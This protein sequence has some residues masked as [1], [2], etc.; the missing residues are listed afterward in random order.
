MDLSI[1]NPLYLRSEAPQLLL[2]ALVS[3]VDM[4]DAEYLRLALGHEAA[5]DQSGARPYIGSHHG[6]PL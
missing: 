5:Y 4:I 1:P 2:D 3:S 6:G